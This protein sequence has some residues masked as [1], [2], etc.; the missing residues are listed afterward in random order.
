MNL[1]DISEKDARKILELLNSA[2]NAEELAS[3][4]E[5][6]GERDVGV[7]VAENILRER[8]RIGKFT[9]LNQLA[10]IPQVGPERLSEIVKSLT[11]R[12]SGERRDNG[13]KIK[14]EVNINL[15]GAAEGEKPPEIAAYIFDSTG[16]FLTTAE[17]QEG[18]VEVEIPSEITGR[19]AR[20]FIGP[21]LG[22]EP[23]TLPVIK[24]KGGYE[25]RVRIDSKKPRVDIAIVASIWKIWWLCS[26]VV[27]GRLVKRITMPDGTTREMPICNSRVTIC[28]VD[29]IPKIIFRLPDDLLYKLKDIIIREPFPFPPGPDPVPDPIPDP[30][31][32]PDPSPEARVILDNLRLSRVERNSPLTEKVEAAISSERKSITQLES[33][34]KQNINISAKVETLK[35][36]SSTAELRNRIADLGE[37]IRPLFCALPWIDPYIKYNVNC[38][39]TVPVDENGR[40]ETTIY[41]PCLGDKPDLYFKAEQLHGFI[42]ESIYEPS[43]RCNTYW[44]YECGT[45]VTINVTDP[46]AVP[47]APED[48]VIPP[49]GVGTWVMPFAVGGTKIWGNPTGSPAAPTGWVKTDGKTDYGGFT[50]APFGGNLGYR[51]GFSINIPSSGIKYYRWS[52]RK[53]GSANWLHMTKQVGRHYV[54][55]EPGQLP[56]FP[57][58]SLGPNT[59]GGNSDLFEFKPNSPPGPSASD[60]AGT[61]TYWPTDDFFAD[62]Y[63]GF[64]NTVALLPGV[65]GA[66]G[67]YQIKLEVFDNA[68]NQVTPGAG[69]FQFIIPI[70]V[71]S[72]GVT[73]LARNARPVELSAGGFV[74]NLHIDN[75]QC[76][77]TIDPPNISGVA[78]ADACGFLRYEPGSALPV[79]IQFHAQHPNN[80]GEFNF[81]IVRGGTYLPSASSINQEVSAINPTPYTGDGSGNFTNDFTLSSLLG[82]CSSA[83]F[84]ET[85]Y[86]FAKATTGWGYRISSYDASA[87]R[88]FALAPIEP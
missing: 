24:S 84:A 82:G 69:T 35:L 20:I 85:L 10:N 36:A 66:A 6:P 63:T 72:D 2:R 41:Y 58:Y 57:V 77:A 3:A 75:N 83:A 5:I 59:V 22:E 74:F 70:G 1:R 68:G 51:H 45:E 61:I 25:K 8:G 46:S 48:P 14:F 7:K 62:I 18:K 34:S 11:E 87:V 30:W 86:V 79:N 40:F 42:W 81:R 52:Y 64:L 17:I 88:A 39:K 37:L 12:E 60:P 29:S 54:H 15:K 49:V 44:N 67:Q 47:C 38:F 56:S 43:I 53:V 19:T 9:D 76:S 28:E 4:V 13:E 78:V 65:E 33:I 21:K 50:D 73:V 27:R 80:F 55:Q 32:G 31:P 26:C 71:A 23:V 16:R